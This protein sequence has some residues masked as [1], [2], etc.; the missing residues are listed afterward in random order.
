[1]RLPAHKIRIICTIGPAPRLE[2]L[3]ERL[4]RLGMNVARLNSAHG[5]LQ[6]HREDIRRI[7]TVAA[8]LQLHCLIM[9][10]LWKRGVRSF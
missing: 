9:A 2:A 6:G 10:D 3:L 4:I 7:G 8:R 1:M 5:T